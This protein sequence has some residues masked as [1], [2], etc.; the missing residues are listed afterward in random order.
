VTSTDRPPWQYPDTRSTL[1][2]WYGGVSAPARVERDGV[3]EALRAGVELVTSWIGVPVTW[4]TTAVVAEDDPWGRDFDVMRPGLD[5][6]FVARAGTPSSVTL[7][8]VATQLAA[9]PTH[10]Y[11]RV[12]EVHAAYPA[13]VDGR[14]VGRMLVAASARQWAL[15]T[16]T[17]G[18]WFAAGLGPWVLAAADAIG[19]D[20]GFA[21]LGDGW[22]TYEQS[23]WER[24][25]GVP[26]ASEPGLLWGYGWGTLLSPGH[27][28][29][30]GGAGALAA[31]LGDVPGAQLHER[32]GGQVWLTLGDDPTDVPDEA[33]RTLHATLLPALAV[34][35]FDEVTARAHRATTPAGLRS[36][37]SGA[38]EEA[39]SA[40]RT[41][42]DFGPTGSTV[43]ALDDLLPVATT[44]LPDALLFEGLG[45]PAATRLAT[46][47][48]DGLLDAH[49]GGGPTLRRALAAAAVHACVTLGG[50]A[51]G[52]AR[53]D[54]RVTVDRVVVR[55]DAVLD[56]LAP[57]AAEQA[58]TRLAELGVDDAPAPPDEVRATS[59]GWVFWWD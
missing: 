11:H 34:P 20:S 21:N 56:A 58:L 33:L 6:G 15:Y 49:V 46:A 10:P 39:R 32:V 40:L 51:I 57:D 55:G 13:Q 50:H 28:A 29:A 31:A 36:M 45:G 48:P 17:D 26:A 3:V 23:A 19:A 59:D 35:Q 25:A 5:W 54:E 30:V 41:E 53:L 12:A 7:T 44:L 47:L 2:A 42:S 16:G 43:V 1:P 37:W 22:A 4:T 14:D 38:L 9:H 27:L 18:P 52:P 24:H 8:A